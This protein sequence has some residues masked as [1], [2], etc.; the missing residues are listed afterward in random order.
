[1]ST[2]PWHTL[3]VTGIHYHNDPQCPGHTHPDEDTC[4][5]EIEH[6]LTHPDDCPPE[7]PCCCPLPAPSTS[8]FAL[9]L[10]RTCAECRKGAHQECANKPT[11]RCH[12]E[13]E[14]S[15]YYSENELPMISGTYRVQAWGHVDYWGEYDGGVNCEDV[16]VP[17]APT[18]PA[19]CE[20]EPWP[21]PPKFTPP[22]LDAIKFEPIQTEN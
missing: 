10:S 12:T 7:R 18:E 13:C 14:V 17:A 3:T 4:D 5:D 22:Q 19:T 20:R 2:D 8:P 16:D 11:F 9:D 6:E 1:M 21:A 15:E